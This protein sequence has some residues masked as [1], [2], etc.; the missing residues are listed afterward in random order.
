MFYCVTLNQEIILKN[1]KFWGIHLTYQAQIKPIVFCN[2]KLP[3][4]DRIYQFQILFIVTA[5]PIN[6]LYLTRFVLS[7]F[8]DK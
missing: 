8:S 5:F 3:G 4:K 6:T 1:G 7:M 2:I